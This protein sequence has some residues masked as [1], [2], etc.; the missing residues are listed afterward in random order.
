MFIEYMTNELK[1]RGVP[2]VTPAGGLGCHVNAREFLSHLPAE[3]YP[4]VALAAAAY[5]CRQY[6]RH[7]TRHA[8][9]AA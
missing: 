4:A 1:S 8:F 9:G 5:N 6:T 3:Q 7:G 2:V